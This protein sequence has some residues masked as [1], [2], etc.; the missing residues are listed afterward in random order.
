[1]NTEIKGNVRYGKEQLGDGIVR[2]SAD[3]TTRTDRDARTFVRSVPTLEIRMPERS[4]SINASSAPAKEHNGTSHC[5]TIVP[6]HD[7]PLQLEF[8]VNGKLKSKKGNEMCWYRQNS[9]SA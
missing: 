3:V 9:F 7:G 5:V 2:P 1:M 8:F 6:A 4:T